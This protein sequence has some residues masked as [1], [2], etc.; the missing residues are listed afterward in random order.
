VGRELGVQFVLAGSLR[1]EGERLQVHVQLS[2]A[3]GGALVWGERFD[4]AD[5]AGWNWRRDVSERV[6]AT[7]D[8]KL[9]QAALDH[10]RHAGRSSE[11]MDQ[12]MRGEYLLRRYTTREV[13]LRARTHFEAALAIEPRSVNAL[14]GLARTHLV[15]VL[16]RWR[17]GRAKAESLGRA[18]EHALAA[19][20]IDPHHPGAMLALGSVFLDANEFEEAERVLTKA[21]TLNPNDAV[22]HR[23]LGALKFSMARFDE[24]QPHIA[25]ALRL[26]PLEPFHV[27]LCHMLL[28]DSL[29]HLG[30]DDAAHEQHLLAVRAEPT[31]PN[32]YFSMASHA[33]LRGRM[34]EARV[35]LARALRMN[36]N[37]SIAGSVA[38]DRSNHPAHLAA[39]NRYREGLRLAGLP[40][41]PPDGA[42]LAPADTALPRGP[43][44][45]AASR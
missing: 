29:M 27:A 26:N 9:L 6:A 19:L 32:V 13:V 21:L 44:A 36:P 31:R 28:G 10:T 37:S 39:R 43:T 23:A 1:R 17:I 4:Y 25:A 15:E 3:A 40:E 38:A 2:R 42:T 14:I 22:V 11:A 24:V 16:G 33:A 34:D 7:L 45:A 8:V 30:L 5:A 18:K 20:A 41:R 35:H 12:W